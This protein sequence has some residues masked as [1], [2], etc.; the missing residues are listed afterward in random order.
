MKRILALSA[1]LLVALAAAAAAEDDGLGNE[2]REFS[3]PLGAKV[4]LLQLEEA[5][6]R[7]ILWGEGIVSAI[8]EKNS[9]A[10]TADLEAILAQMRALRDEVNSTAP[11]GGEEAAK[12]FVDMKDDALSLTKE[13]R[14]GA[15]AL[16]SP[17]DIPGL[18]K[19]L[20]ELKKGEFDEFKRRIN[21]T[22]REY[23]AQKLGEILSAA[24]LSDPQLVDDVKAGTAG[25]KDVREFL[26]S[27]LGNMTKEDRRKAFQAVQE[28]NVK[29]NVFLRAV[30]DKVMERRLE[31]VEDRVGKRLR[32]AQEANVSDDVLERLQNRSGWVERRL[33]LVRE[34]DEK[35]LA[36]IG[37]WT[38]KTVGK[39]E[40][41]IDKAENR[42]DKL[43]GRLEERLDGNIS[44]RRAGR[45]EDRLGRLGNR[46]NRIV[47]RIEDRIGRVENRGDKWKERVDGS[48]GPGQGNGD[49][50]GQGNGG[51]Q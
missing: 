16:I 51:G 46:T 10:D 14:D 28:V 48:P 24:G 44:D 2:T 3:S 6:E 38:E 11:E 36:R 47:E 25:L 33:E 30:L 17:G 42:S 7:N 12:R 26:R 39:L 22:R 49:G 45:I 35:W 31:R 13:F 29:G 50:H 27:S 23:N 9:S 19:R 15:R 21:Q 5:L 4:R 1:A 40:D 20:G 41:K 18:R 34:Q 37:N 8:R 43:E 32:R